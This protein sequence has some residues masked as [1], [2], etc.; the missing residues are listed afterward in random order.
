MAKF[1]NIVLRANHD[2]TK[3]EK[4]F[5]AIISILIM[6]IPVTDAY[7]SFEGKYLAQFAD[8]FVLYVIVYFLK[9]LVF[10]FGYSILEHV[11][12]SCVPNK[13]K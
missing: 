12:I 2:L 6:L 4:I 5:F 13:Q 1:L 9:I 8:K 10:W 3:S 11:L 7:L